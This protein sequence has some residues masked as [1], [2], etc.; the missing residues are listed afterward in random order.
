MGFVEGR[1]HGHA[2]EQPGEVLLN[3]RVRP[4]F[5]HLL[6]GEAL[7]GAVKVAARL[8]EILLLEG[9]VDGGSDGK[10][11]GEQDGG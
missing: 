1:V 11:G 8:A 5:L 4:H 7:D 3:Q 10:E 2:H 6:P 9:I